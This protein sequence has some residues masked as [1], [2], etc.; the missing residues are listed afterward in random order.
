[1][2]QEQVERLW[3]RRIVSAIMLTAIAVGAVP[4]I[5]N[6]MFPVQKTNR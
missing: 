3:F 6:M 2:E 4:V 5:K 1:M